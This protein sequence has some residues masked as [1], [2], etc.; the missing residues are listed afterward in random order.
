MKKFAAVL[1]CLVACCLV[2]S[3]C[4]KQQKEEYPAID[5]SVYN[6]VLKEVKEV[7]KL[8]GD[9]Q[10]PEGMEGIYELAQV[11]GENAEKEL[12]Y[13]Y[14][15]LN[16]DHIPELLLGVTNGGDT[17]FVQ[18][19]I[20]LI[21]TMENNQPLQILSGNSKNMYALLSDGHL[22]TFA[23]A[24]AAY[25]IFG[26][27]YLEDDYQLHCKD[28]YFT[29]EVDGDFENI[30]VFYNS[31]GNF[32]VVSSNLQ[33]ISLQEFEELQVELALRTLPLFDY[34]PIADFQDI[35]G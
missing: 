7:L 1:S 32:D 31:T 22:A 12:C 26:E 28:F 24:G 8:P 33:D 5:F 34:I 6:T 27:F 9:A 21:Y 11:L 14:E 19:Q 4:L 15:D 20:Y 17:S 16:Q 25:S 10:A 18:N 13:Q 23:S 2:F 3:G 35:A 29:H 30:G